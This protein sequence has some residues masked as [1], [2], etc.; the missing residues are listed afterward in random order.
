MLK[1]YFPKA[2]QTWQTFIEHNLA[3]T[4][5]NRNGPLQSGFYEESSKNT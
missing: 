4:E 3:T 5:G 2:C 1:V